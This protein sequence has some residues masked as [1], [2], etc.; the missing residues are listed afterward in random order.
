MGDIQQQ[1]GVLLGR[2]TVKIRKTGE[3]PP[4]ISVVDVVVALTGKLARHSADVVRDLCGRY[5]EVNANIVDFK[6]PG[7]GQRKTSVTDA[8]G[9]VEIVMLLPGRQAALVRRQ[10]AELL[11]R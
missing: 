11:V 8:G 3:V 10:A 9:I 7:R 5:P 6:F 2:E 4:R 1:L